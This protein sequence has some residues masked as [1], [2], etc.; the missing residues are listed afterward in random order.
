ML[1]IEKLFYDFTLKMCQM[2]DVRCQMSKDQT[3]KN[4]HS[5][6]LKQRNHLTTNN[7]LINEILQKVFTIAFACEPCV[8]LSAH[9]KRFSVS[10]MHNFVLK[11][12]ISCLFVCFFVLKLKD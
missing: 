12:K 2:S 9:V 7:I 1:S 5:I 4:I 8:L 11:L 10:S 6:K 3:K